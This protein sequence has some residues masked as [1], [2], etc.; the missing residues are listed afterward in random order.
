MGGGIPRG[1]L[2]MVM[3]PPGSGKTTLANQMAFHAATTGRRVLVFSALSES[4]MKLIDHLRVYAFFDLNVIGVSLQI[5]SLQQYLSQGL[6]DT[7]ER[8]IEAARDNKADFVVLDGFRGVRGAEVD[9]QLARQFL[10]DIGS[11][12]SIRGTTTVITSEAAPRDPTFF[13]EATT[14]DII[15]GLHFNLVDIRTFRGIEVIKLRGAEALPGVHGFGLDAT[16]HI[17]YPRLEAQIAAG[18]LQP[19]IVGASLAGSVP[20]ATPTQQR[21]TF[22]L[23][24]LD[25]LLHGGVPRATSTVVTGS[26]GVG[27]T[28]LALHFALASAQAG[29][30]TVFVSFRETLAQ[31][32]E[33][34]DAFVLGKQLRTALGPEGNLTFLRWE[35]VELEPDKLADDL[36]A[37]LD[38]LKARRVV[39]DSVAEMQHALT[40]YSGRSRLRNYLSAWYAALRNRSVTSLFVLE[41]HKMAAEDVDFAAEPLGVLAENVLH[42]QQTL[43]EHNHRLI[44]VVKMRFSSHELATRE[45]TITAPAGLQVLP[46]N[47]TTS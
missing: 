14:A 15:L 8:I 22:A 9:P 34:A 17:I 30:P 24:E 38:T 46:A 10:Y 35:P 4:T 20:P 45:Y 2:M 18:A 1:S 31:L 43:G 40:E 21:A 19:A 33:K 36:L 6:E 44:S 13:P 25:A 37:M 41:T 39:V 11:A 12:L 42:L 27:K 5:F 23:P 26:L 7:G 3:G 29:E 28:L 47:A 32:L 16:G